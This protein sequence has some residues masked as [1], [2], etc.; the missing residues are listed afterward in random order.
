[1][2]GRPAFSEYESSALDANWSPLRQTHQAIEYEDRVLKTK[3][4]T[5]C[6]EYRSKSPRTWLKMIKLLQ[7]NNWKE[8]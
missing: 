1:M 6:F 4:T 7:H 2:K 3:I 8:K 5:T